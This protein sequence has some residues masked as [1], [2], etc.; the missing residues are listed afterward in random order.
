MV[1]VKA[2][3]S[4]V[5]THRVHISSHASSFKKLPSINLPNPLV[6]PLTR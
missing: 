6:L 1:T 5:P 3:P 4:K 2:I